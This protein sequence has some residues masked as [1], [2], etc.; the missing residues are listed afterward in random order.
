VSAI[1]PDA[2]HRLHPMLECG[3]VGAGFFLRRDAARSLGYVSWLAAVG[4]ACRVQCCLSVGMQQAFCSH[5]TAGRSC[6]AH[7]DQLPPAVASAALQLCAVIFLGVLQA[8]G[9]GGAAYCV[10]WH[11]LLVCSQRQVVVCQGAVCM[12]S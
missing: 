7:P 3:G 5:M 9:S 10:Q 1:G 11:A 4:F 2:A 12:P 8:G 6:F